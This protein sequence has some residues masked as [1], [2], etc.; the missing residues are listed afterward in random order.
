MFVQA[1]DSSTASMGPPNAEAA[2][3]ITLKKQGFIAIITINIP[4]K[5]NAMNQAH[6]FRIATLL[7]EIAEMPDIAVTVVTAQ[8]RFFSA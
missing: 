2:K 8:G 3:V 6:Y 1:L 4:H 7:L 5:L